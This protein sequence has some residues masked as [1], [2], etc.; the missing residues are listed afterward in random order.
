MLTE[1][2]AGLE[3]GWF[4]WAGLVEGPCWK[5]VDVSAGRKDEV[6]DLGTDVGRESEEG[7]SRTWDL[8]GGLVGVS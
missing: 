2:T 1:A 3:D 4:A 8:T 6:E 7:R 5:D